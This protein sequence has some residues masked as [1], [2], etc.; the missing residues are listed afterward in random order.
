MKS[1]FSKPTPA[2]TTGYDKL[3]AAIL[4]LEAALDFTYRDI[5]NHIA[6]MGKKIM[7]QA[8]SNQ[9]HLNR[10]IAGIQA[11][12]ATAISE[13]KTQIAAGVP[14]EQLDF[15]AADRLAADV[16]AEA[17]RDAPVAAGPVTGPA[18]VPTP[19][20]PTPDTGIGTV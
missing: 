15:S 2:Q 19:A 12:F 20:P 6:E 4:Q 1:F 3:F 9:D 14:S 8:E 17:T 18:T 5:R 7:T 13:L 10:D 11:S 16:A